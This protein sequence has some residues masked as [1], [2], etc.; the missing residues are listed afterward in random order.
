MPTPAMSTEEARDVLAR[1]VG[2]DALARLDAPLDEAAGLPNAAFTSDAF[3]ALEQSRLAY[4]QAPDNPNMVSRLA[5]INL[6]TSD[7]AAAGRLQPDHS[8]AD[9]RRCCRS[10]PGYPGPA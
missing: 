4:E 10:V 2:A 7:L 8:G 1:L 6:W 9:R 3:F 5:I